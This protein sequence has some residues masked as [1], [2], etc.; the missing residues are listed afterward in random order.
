MAQKPLLK[1][2]TFPKKL[3]PLDENLV[4]AAIFKFYKGQNMWVNF[5]KNF[6]SW[7]FWLGGRDSSCHNHP[8]LWTSFSKT[9]TQSQCEARISN[10]L[11]RDNLNIKGKYFRI[12]WVIVEKHSYCAECKTQQGTKWQNGVL[13]LFLSMNIHHICHFIYTGILCG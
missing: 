7:N 1:G 9:L 12:F 3:D 2:D 11:K 6:L 4:F 8:P 5:Q 10:C 13:T